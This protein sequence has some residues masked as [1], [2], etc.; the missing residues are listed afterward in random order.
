MTPTQRRLAR[1]ALGLPNPKCISYRNRFIGAVGSYD[2]EIWTGMCKAGLALSRAEPLT[3]RVKASRFWLTPAGALAAL[4][5][6]ETLCPEDFP[7]AA[8][9]AA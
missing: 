6:G 9:S 1:L 4:N 7:A 2:H 5:P 8:G 3:A